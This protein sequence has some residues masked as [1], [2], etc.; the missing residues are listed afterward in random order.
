MNV[1]EFMLVMIIA[2]PLVAL[3]VGCII[4]IIARPDLSGIKK[5]LWMLLVLF[6]PLF[7]SLIYVIVRPRNPMGSLTSSPYYTGWDGS[8]AG[9]GNPTSGVGAPR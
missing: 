3:W 8:G 1:W 4:D 6:F 7:G 2:L 5:A 9:M